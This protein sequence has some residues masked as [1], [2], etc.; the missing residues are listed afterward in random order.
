MFTDVFISS[1]LLKILK[2]C[3][4]H[5]DLRQFHKARNM[6]VKRFDTCRGHVTGS[7]SHYRWWLCT[8]NHFPTHFT[9]FAWWSSVR[10]SWLQE[11]L[12]EWEVELKL[13][14]TIGLYGNG[15]SRVKHAYCKI[16]E[17]LWQM[18]KCRGCIWWKVNKALFM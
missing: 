6:V 7:W 9:I 3:Y 13:L 5:D 11:K 1:S 4:N 8:M 12:S 16:S 2:F 10:L 14:R 18:F 15:V 17:E